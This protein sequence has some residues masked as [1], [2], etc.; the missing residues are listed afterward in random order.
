MKKLVILIMAGVLLLAAT[1]C[2]TT[3]D[4]AA[5]DM[6]ARIS[7]LEAQLQEAQ[8]KEEIRNLVDQFSNLADEKNPA[9]QMKLFTPDAEVIINMGESSNTMSYAQTEEAFTRVLTD[10]DILY[11][12]NGQVSIEVDGDTATG[13]VY[14]R[15]VLIDENEDG[16]MMETDE[17]VIYNDEYVKQDGKW[18]IARRSS[19][20]LYQDIRPLSN[21]Q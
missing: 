16:I 4:T 13:V 7:I 18:L 8:D 15:V 11:H 20:F 14:C 19:N 3:T 9:D 5:E 1:A 10:T 2:G 6:S 21:G 17:G 12:M